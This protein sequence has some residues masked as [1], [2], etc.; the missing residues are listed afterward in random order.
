MAATKE[1]P[2]YKL[3]IFAEEDKTD[4]AAYNQSMS[5]IDTDMKAVEGKADGAGTSAGAAMNTAQEALTQAG[6]AVTTA[7]AASTAAGE[8]KTIANNATVIAGDAQTDAHASL[9]ASNK[10]TDSI[11]NINT[12]LAS[13]T[14]KKTY[15]FNPMTGFSN[16]TY[17]YMN[18]LVA[19]AEIQSTIQ[20]VDID[21]SEY[22]S[23][24]VGDNTWCLVHAGKVPGN[25]FNINTHTPN[26]SDNMT[27]LGYPPQIYLKSDGSRVAGTDFTCCII[28]DGTNTVLCYWI[29]GAKPSDGIMDGA[30]AVS[31]RAMSVFVPVGSYIVPTSL[32]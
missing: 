5:L 14:S 28:Y 17:I 26:T 31:M 23:V 30:T 24:T 19:A 10:N 22:E 29:H 25:I 27:S 4:W 6:N 1:T 16:P 32:Y 15:R 3:P 7:N 8:A 13:I 2:N 11:G 9:K 12:E 20:V 18:G 21:N